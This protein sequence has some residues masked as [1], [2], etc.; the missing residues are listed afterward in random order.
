MQQRS[1]GSMPYVRR[2]VFAFL[3]RRDDT[4]KRVGE[5]LHPIANAQY[6]LPRRKNVLR[7][8]RCV[9]LIDAARPAGQYVA[10]RLVPVDL[11]RVSVEREHF[12]IN[13][14]FAH[15]AGNQL[16]VLGAVIEDGSATVPGVRHKL[17]SWMCMGDFRS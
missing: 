12:G 13:A 3:R 11:L 2:A 6:R 15:A 16:R 7:K 4:A 1:L 9:L 17:T 5:R 8:L 10:A 14:L